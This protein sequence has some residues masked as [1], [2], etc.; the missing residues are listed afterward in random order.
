MRLLLLEDDPKLNRL[1]TRFF[2]EKFQLDSCTTYSDA[3]YHISL[4]RYDIVLLDR[5]LDGDDVGLNLLKTIKEKDHTTGVI[6]ISAYSDAIQKI[7]G[8][9]LGA[10][11]Y[12][13]KPFDINELYARII[14]LG[15]RYQPIINVIEGIHF[16]MQNEIVTYEEVEIKFS[17]KESALLFYLVKKSNTILSKELLLNTL[18]Q[19]PQNIASNIIDVTL[20]NIRKKLPHNIIE[21]IKTRGY[22]ISKK[23]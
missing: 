2:G 5:N 10:D 1:L 19:N 12:L 22:R 4:Y 21:T 13:D 11:D 17:K 8:L 18:Y 14:A 16:D 6:V 9:E 20:A 15:R 23:D 7:K 3:A